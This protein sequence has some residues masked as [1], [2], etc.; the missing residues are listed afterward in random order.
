MAYI[1]ANYRVEKCMEK[2]ELHELTSISM[3]M[4]IP[5]P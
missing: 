2:Y 1:R 4:L 3:L 5:K